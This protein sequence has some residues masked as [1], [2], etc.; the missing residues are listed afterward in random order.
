MR[1]G[2]LMIGLLGLAAG[3]AWA[4]GAERLKAFGAFYR[5]LGAAETNYAI[6][7][8][9]AEAD[10]RNET[11]FALRLQR[12]NLLHVRTMD[13]K[14]GGTLISDGKQIYTGLRATRRYTLEPA[15]ATFADWNT[16]GR[17]L[18]TPGVDLVIELLGRQAMLSDLDTLKHAGQ[19][20]INEQPCDRFVAESGGRT[21]TLWIGRG[22]PWLW[23]FRSEADNVRMTLNFEDWRSAPPPAEA[24]RIDPPEGMTKVD[25]HRPP[26][27]ARPTQAGRSARPRPQP[28]AAGQPAP[29]FEATLLDGGSVNLADHLGKDVIVLDFW[30]TW[31]KPCLMAMPVLIEET[32]ARKDRGVVFYAVNIAE[33]PEKVKKL[34]D[35]KGWSFPVVL[36][37]SAKIARSFG[38]GPI[39]HSV[40][41]GR[42]G[43]IAH[44]HVGYSSGLRA[45]LTAELDG[46]LR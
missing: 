46:L 45:T 21:V 22:R 41:I 8:E 25:S 37:R 38:V 13:D 32:A 36:D 4:D 39:P 28:V 35:G 27:G 14:Q 3:P 24:F 9:L 23:R 5:E 12:P 26:R 20:T 19:E 34:M 10:F 6:Q 43:K 17:A 7:V 31:C 18:P 16:A 11:R 29:A 2:V 15:P 33:Q 44:V 1:L 30:A 42:D 40:V